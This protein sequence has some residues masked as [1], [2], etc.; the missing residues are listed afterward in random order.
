MT[1]TKTRTFTILAVA[2]CLVAG[3]T[4]TALAQ[5]PG[6]GHGGPGAH[7][8]GHHGG[9]HGPPIE[10]LARFLA[11]T[12][13]QIEAAKA[14]REATEAQV[15]PIR[16]A[17]KALHEELRTLLDAEAPDATAVGEVA[18]EL[19]EGREQIHALREQ[20]KADFEALLTAEQRDKLERLKD[21]RRHFGQPRW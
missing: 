21:V 15:A 20:A 5:G 12:D 4:V 14:I 7:R 11:L 6:R 8:G 9:H 19:H 18:I 17:Q 1:L 3:L 10:R 13:E 16:Q 2:L